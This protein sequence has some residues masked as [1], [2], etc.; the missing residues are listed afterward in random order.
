MPL[1]LA[2]L[3]ILCYIVATGL[4]RVE[5]ARAEARLTQSAMNTAIDYDRL[6]QDVLW[7]GLLETNGRQINPLSLSDFVYMAR[8]PNN[9]WVPDAKAYIWSPTYADLTA[10]LP[11]AL[12]VVQD[13]A[14]KIDLNQTQSEY[15]RFIAERANLPGGKDRAVRDLQAYIAERTPVAM[16]GDGSLRILQR[17]GLQDPVEICSIPSWS[18]WELCKTPEKLRELTTAGVGL[19]PNIRIA[20]PE[21]KTFLLGRGFAGETGTQILE[22]EWVET[23]VNYGFYSPVQGLG[24]GGERFTVTILPRGAARAL[25]FELDARVQETG[26]PYAVRARRY[27]PAEELKDDYRQRFPSAI[28]ALETG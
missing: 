13:E 14:T 8:N 4:Q 5:V 10:E 17:S 7:R 22:M 2:V 27:L 25:R 16:S 6:E 19:V 15:I 23:R 28:R 20:S 3:V 24:V 21:A 9:L 12:V 26:L 11:R 18:G 1:T